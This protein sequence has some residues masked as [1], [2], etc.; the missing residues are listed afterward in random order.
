MPEKLMPVRI[1]PLRSA[2]SSTMVASG[3]SERHRFQ[4]FAPNFSRVSSA[5][6][7]D[8]SA[9]ATFCMTCRSGVASI[10]NTTEETTDEW[11]T[12]A[13]W[14]EERRVCSDRRRQAGDVERQR[15]SL[16]WLGDLPFEGLSG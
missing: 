2:P 12:C 6:I 9:L 13:R 14:N 3:F 11:S 4:K 16:R 5:F 1:I 15:S 8:F 10:D 7:G